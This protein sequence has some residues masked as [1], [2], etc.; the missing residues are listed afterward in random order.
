MSGWHRRHSAHVVIE[1]GVCWRGAGTSSP[2]IASASS[3]LQ[4]GSV[5][6]SYNTSLESSSCPETPN[7]S[8]PSE[9]GRAR[10]HEQDQRRTVAAGR[11]HC[12][13]QRPHRAYT[14]AGRV[15]AVQ[16]QSSPGLEITR[17][18]AWGEGGTGGR[19]RHHEREARPRPSASC[20]GGRNC[21]TTTGQYSTEWSVMPG[22]ERRPEAESEYGRHLKRS[23]TVWNRWSGWY[24]MSERDFEPYRTRVISH[25]ELD[26]GARV[27]EIGCGPGV[28]F[29]PIRNAIGASGSLVA[30]DYSPAMVENAT[31]RV[32]TLGWEN[33]EVVRADATT[34][35][36]DGPFDAAIATLAL[37]VMPDVD[38]AVRNVHCALEPG[39]RFGVLDVQA[40][41][42]GPLRV[43]NPLLKRF[44]RWYANWNPTAD[45][46]RA[47][48]T[49]FDDVERLGTFML[50]TLY[51]LVATR[52]AP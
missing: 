38:R 41:Q 28:N 17:S 3:W 40:V 37:S 2:T 13:S 10:R 31:E 15:A 48:A 44:F 16:T 11:V 8:E 23:E 22:A 34:A 4:S 47:V 7:V 46:R 49:V 30:I 45:V 21:Q 24:R 50:G 12:P 6:R 39:G 29:A 27:L 9:H 25:L 19:K 14:P 36:L 26:E 33:I 43:C 18:S 1:L 52:T 51:A 42:S 5:W 32:E 20:G 35:D